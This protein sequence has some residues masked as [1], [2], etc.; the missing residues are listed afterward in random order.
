[1][2]WNERSEAEKTFAINFIENVDELW[3]ENL[4]ADEDLWDKE[5]GDQVPDLHQ[6]R[7]ERT[8]GSESRD[9][10]MFWTFAP[11]VYKNLSDESAR[12]RLKKI[13]DWALIKDTSLKEIEEDVSDTVHL[14]GLRD[15]YY[16]LDGVYYLTIDPNNLTHKF[17][18]QEAQR[19]VKEGV[20][21]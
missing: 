15:I 21:G 9:S 19:L 1:M 2:L 6:P 20:F 4:K 8:F 18:D 3:D 14:K 13:F 17:T 16:D 10:G 7:L 11:Y 5:S 12:D